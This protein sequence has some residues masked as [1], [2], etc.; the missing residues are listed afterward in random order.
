MLTWQGNQPNQQVAAL[1][2]ADRQ[3]LEN[4]IANLQGTKQEVDGHQR[5]QSVLAELHQQGWGVNGF[6]RGANL[7]ESDLSET[8]LRFFD[9]KG[10]NLH[11]ASLRGSDLRFANLRVADLHAADLSETNLADANLSSANLRQVNLSGANFYHTALNQADFAE[12]IVGFTTFNDVNLHGVK[13]LDRVLHLRGPSSIGVDTLYRSEGSI[14]R[15]FL[16]G[17][18][19]PEMMITFLKSLTGKA[20]EYY[21]CFISHSTNDQIFCDRL[22]SRFRQEKVRVWYAPEDLK[23]GQNMLGQI[24]EAIRYHD[25]L[26]VVLSR[27]S[28][29]SRWVQ[30]EISRTLEK[31]QENGRRMLFP[32]SII[33]FDDLRHWECYDDEGNDLAAAVLDCY[34]PDFTQWK[35]HDTFEKAF[36][37]LLYDLQVD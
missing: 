1:P 32:I 31:E 27:H 17:C 37:R 29:R 21:S 2:P 3:W 6:L 18:G 8:D 19:V 26:V 24:D 7:T 34:I 4:L 22:Y 9:L 25:K 36:A 10:A 15:E 30:M 23:G 5:A 12:A 33:P 11:R 13:N 16:E 35:Y 14:P 28:M 20:I